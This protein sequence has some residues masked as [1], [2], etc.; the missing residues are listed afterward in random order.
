VI[1]V[2][3]AGW[4]ASSLEIHAEESWAE[5]APE[6]EAVCVA[7]RLGGKNALAFDL[8]DADL[9]VDGLSTLS[10]TEDERAEDRDR[11]RRDPEGTRFAR[12][13]SDG[14]SKLSIRVCAAVREATASA[15][16]DRAGRPTAG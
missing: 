15:G 4:A 2:R 6:I 10:N 11:K 3:C 16:R 13:S 9:V 8:A 7:F 1:R 14:L 5:D 12:L